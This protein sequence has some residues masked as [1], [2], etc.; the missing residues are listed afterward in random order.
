V[1]EVTVTGPHRG[2]ILTPLE[3]LEGFIP[4]SHLVTVTARAARQRASRDA[5]HL[6]GQSSTSRC[7]R[8]I[9]TAAG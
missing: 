5:H 9:K 4:S 6:V 7:S 3:L 8:S 2:G 1:V